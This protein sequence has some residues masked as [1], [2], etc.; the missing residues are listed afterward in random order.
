MTRPFRGVDGARQREDDE[1]YAT[2][3]FW[4]AAQLAFPSPPHR[5]TRPRP[6]AHYEA[7]EPLRALR[8][9]ADQAGFYEADP[10]LSS[11]DR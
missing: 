9:P 2:P 8:P 10:L 1:G 4:S 6:E 3:I 5:P 11:D 7:A